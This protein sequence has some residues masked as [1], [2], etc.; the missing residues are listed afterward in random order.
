MSNV[1]KRRKL[2][3]LPEETY[4][5][6]SENLVDKVNEHRRVFHYVVMNERKV[7]RLVSDLK[8]ERVKLRTLKKR[9]TELNLYIDP[10]RK[11]FEFG[12]SISSL[13][14]RKSGKVYYNLSINRSGGS[15]PISLGSDKIILKHL[16]EYYEGDEKKLG[17]IRKDW[18]SFVKYECMYNEPYNR[19]LEM[20][21]TDPIKFR[22][23][24]ISR[25]DI[26]PIR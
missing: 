1:I 24:T 22:S 12:V 10:L 23:R 8:K 14:P 21:V 11:E 9:L 16:L 19:I 17:D 7:Q 20:I 5:N 4:K 18:K 6:L 13:P 26:F 15:K 2:E 25:K 3:Y